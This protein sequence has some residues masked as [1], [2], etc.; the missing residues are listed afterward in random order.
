MLRLNRL[1][2]VFSCAIPCTPETVPG[3]RWRERERK[4]LAVPMTG[5]R[6]PPL[7]PVLRSCVCSSYSLIG[8]SSLVNDPGVLVHAP[9]DE[10]N[11]NGM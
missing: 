10:S 8:E 11:Q 3:D 5:N 2:L 6:D 1:A 7:S 9:T 4:R